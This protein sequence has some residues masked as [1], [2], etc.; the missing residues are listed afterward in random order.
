M[1][2]TRNHCLQITA[3]PSML[4]RSTTA[5]HPEWKTY[6]AIKTITSGNAATTGDIGHVLES[7]LLLSCT[8][9]MKCDQLPQVT[10]M[11]AL[12]REHEAATINARAAPSRRCWL[13]RASVAACAGLKRHLWHTMLH[14][15]E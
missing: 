15:K 4:S 10:P 5:T 7:V 1:H 3:A 8:N 12:Q 14:Q 13:N 11:T 2:C 6:S 9:S